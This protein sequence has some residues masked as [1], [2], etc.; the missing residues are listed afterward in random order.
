M[1]MRLSEHELISP[2]DLLGGSG[3]QPFLQDIGG[4]NASTGWENMKG[5][6]RGRAYVELGSWDSGDDLDESKVQSN[7][8]SSGAA[9]AE[10]TTDLSGGNYDTDAPIDADGDFIITE[11]RAEDL[12][13]DSAELYVRYYVAEAGNTGTDNACGYMSLYG[14]KYPRKELQGAAAAASQVYVDPTT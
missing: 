9:T 12:D 13:V 2:I 6:D 11:F 7:T 14:Y 1:G 4:T 10:V 3:G 5:Y 8:A